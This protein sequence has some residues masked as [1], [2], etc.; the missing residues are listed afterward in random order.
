MVCSV[1]AQHADP[2]KNAYRATDRVTS[3]GV[4]WE[5]DCRTPIQWAPEARSV[6]EDLSLPLPEGLAPAQ[7][8]SDVVIDKQPTQN[9][10]QLEASNAA[11]A[12]AA[13]E[14]AA[15]EAEAAAI[16]AEA[17]MKEA[18]AAAE[19]ARD[20]QGETI[21]DQAETRRTEPPEPNGE[22]S[23]LAPPAGEHADAKEH[24]EEPK[25]SAVEAATAPEQTVRMH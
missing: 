7:A 1:Q 14:A 6:F 25:L 17:A 21:Q 18:E 24:A 20:A 10:V 13:A 2:Y 4:L 8:A 23:V 16:A 11:T 9:S 22:A 5:K 3:F 12:V 19:M 15:A